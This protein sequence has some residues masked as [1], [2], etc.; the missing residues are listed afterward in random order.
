[1]K[2]GR[3]PHLGDED[4]TSKA[5]AELLEI[6]KNSGGRTIGVVRIRKDGRLVVTP[7]EASTQHGEKRN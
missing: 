7:V 5:D 1:M 2:K 6:F 4:E 3:Y